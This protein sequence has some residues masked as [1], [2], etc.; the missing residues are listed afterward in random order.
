[1]ALSRGAN[2]RI[3]TAA[4]RFRVC[5]LVLSTLHKAHRAPDMIEDVEDTGLTEPNE[6]MASR[7]GH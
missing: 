6:F 3:V 5:G 2:T 7:G 1:M 4:S